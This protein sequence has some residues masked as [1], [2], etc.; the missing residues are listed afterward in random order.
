MPSYQEHLA[1]IKA[2]EGLGVDIVV[3][4]ECLNCLDLLGT[5]DFDLDIHF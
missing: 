1:R 4:G 3:S 2:K 5:R